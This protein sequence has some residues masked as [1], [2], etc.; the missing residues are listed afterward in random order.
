MIEAI[1]RAQLL[2]MRFGGIRRSGAIFSVVTGAVFY[3]LWASLAFGAMRYFAAPENAPLFTPVLSGGLLFVVVYWQFAPVLSASFGASLDLRKL[4]V[5][6]VPRGTLFTVEVLLRILTCGE[7]LILLA[8]AMLGLL[9]NPLY[10]LAWSPFILSGALI[11]AAANVLFSTGA[12]YLLEHLFRRARMKEALTL[13]IIAVS[14]TPQ[15]LLFANVKKAALLRFAPSQLIWPWAAAARLM[16][17]DRLAFSIPVALAWL[18]IAWGFG[19]WQFESALRFDAAGQKKNEAESRFGGLAESLFRIPS[20]FLPDPVAALVEKELR[21]LVRISR[22]RIAYFM[23][24]F[25]GTI[26]LYFPATM[27]PH[28]GGDSFFLENALPF[29]ALYGLLMLGQ[30]SYWN[31]F[32]FDRSATQGYFSWPIR[33]RDVLVA[34][35][36]AVALLLV[37]QIVIIA[38]VA[39]AARMP[40]SFERLI[41]TFVVI[42]IASLYWFSMGNICSVRLPRAMDPE[43]MNQMSNKLQ[44]LTILAAPLLLLPLALAYWSRAVFENEYIFAALLMLAAAIGAILYRLGLDSAVAAAQRTRESM[45]MQLARSDAPLSVT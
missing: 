45:L 8:G 25:L 37:P 39:V 33:F 22:F 17:H 27:R 31:S 2:S 43:R 21:T 35:N 3:G 36:I 30:I 34:K 32:G 9:R 4:L 28:R 12:R 20:R 38:V 40:F 24:C 7:M 11:F 23:S 41:E 15:I 13:L 5:Y 26:V 19:R 1:L 44:A 42:A 16:L 18:G 6:P 14:V 10:G 29:I